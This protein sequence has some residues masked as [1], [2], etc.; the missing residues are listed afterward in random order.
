VPALFVFYA[1]FRLPQRPVT[2]RSDALRCHSDARAA[3]T[4]THLRSVQRYLAGFEATGL[5]GLEPAS[6]R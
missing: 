4:A 2:M 5:A 3:E 1:R 6:P